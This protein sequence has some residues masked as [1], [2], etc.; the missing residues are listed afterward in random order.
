M[1]DLHCD[2]SNQFAEGIFFM[3]NVLIL[4]H[5]YLINIDLHFCI[6]G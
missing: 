2:K 1:L 4:M 6:V 5:S 3:I